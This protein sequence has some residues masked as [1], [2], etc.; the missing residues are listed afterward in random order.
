MI[1]VALVDDDELMRAGLRMIIDQ[2]PGISVI[3]EAS[4][5]EEGVRV[6]RLDRPDLVLMDIRMPGMDGIAATEVIATQPDGPKVVILTTFDI[7]EYVFRALR[8]GASGFLLKRTPPE[9]LVSGIRAVAAGDGLLSPSVTGRLIEEFASSTGPAT[10]PNDPRIASLTDREREVL[11]H[12]ARGLT[13]DELGEALF[14]SA[15][16]VKTHVRHVIAKLGSRDR[17]QAVVTAYE[18]GLMR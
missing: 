7:D 13:N 11:V 2:A 16:T 17:V 5:G 4:N 10:E 9:E 6:S 18:S 12:M 3:A 14:I 8:A 1:T 15:N